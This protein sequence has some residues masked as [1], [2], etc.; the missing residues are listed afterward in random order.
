M[1]DR[2]KKTWIIFES[3][4]GSALSR[5]GWLDYCREEL[6]E[7]ETEAW[8]KAQAA[9]LAIRIG[10]EARYRVEVW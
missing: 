5:D 6:P 4:N 2:E 7:G 9:A 8:A 1:S 3:R 10:F